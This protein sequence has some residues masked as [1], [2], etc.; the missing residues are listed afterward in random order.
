MGLHARALFK[1]RPLLMHIAPVSS[2]YYE[3][4][5]ARREQPG[6]GAS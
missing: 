6:L 5:V 3:H 1:P 4:V 2:S